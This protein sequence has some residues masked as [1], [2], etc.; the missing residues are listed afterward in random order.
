MSSANNSH[1]SVQRTPPYTGPLCAEHEVA[2]LDFDDFDDVADTVPARS[3][4]HGAA[5]E[6]LDPR[7]WIS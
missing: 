4:E 1:A 5:Y 2:A 3:V 7:G 6:D